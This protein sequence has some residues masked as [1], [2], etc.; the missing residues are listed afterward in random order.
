MKI[1]LNGQEREARE[2]ETILEM[3]RREGIPIPTFCYYQAF[4]GQ[5]ACRMCMVELRE[6][7]Q[8]QTRL[9]AAC[10][11]PIKSSVEIIT[12]SE[13]IQRLRRTIVMLLAR[14]APDNPLME[15]L[16]RTY[17][18]PRLTAIEVEPP[19]CI[20]CGLCIHAC[21]EMG[22]TAIWSMFRGIDKR[23]GTPY[24]E[25]SEDCIGCAA[26]ARICPTQAINL[27]EEGS[28]RR[29][30]NKTFELVACQRCGKNYTTREELEYL[31]ERTEYGKEKLCESCRKK[32]LAINMKSFQ[33]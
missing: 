7:G 33:Q 31:W 22:R 28:T 3:C 9:V 4:G 11:Y 20:L 26:C 14:R 17:S 32:T 10:T 27:E 21:E 18:S 12:E 15:A 5:G 16:A 1:M 30:W 29:I 19:N 13:R 6:E 2:G 8:E 25:A 23:I 24:D